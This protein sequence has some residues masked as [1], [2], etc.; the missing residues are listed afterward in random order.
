MSRRGRRIRGWGARLKPHVE[1]EGETYSR[2]LILTILEEI[3]HSAPGD[4]QLFEDLLV[5][6]HN[7]QQLWAHV[8]ALTAEGFIS[9]MDIQLLQDFRQAA[10]KQ[11]QEDTH[12]AIQE[13]LQMGL[14]ERYVDDNGETRTKLTEKGRRV[15]AQE[16]PE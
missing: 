1:G 10:E 12:E 11:A 4:I 3:E 13:L 15:A 5:D 16:I 7:F 9:G 8:F 6:G 14:V 2:K